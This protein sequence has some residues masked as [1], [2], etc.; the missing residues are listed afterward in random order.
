VK[1]GDS[2]AK[3]ALALL[4]A[5]GASVLCECVN[6][7]G[8]RVAE[9]RA[10]LVDV[11]WRVLDDVVEQAGD[12][13]LLVGAGVAQESATACAWGRPFARADRNAVVGIEK[14]IDR[15]ATN[16]WE[17]FPNATQGE[18]AA[19]PPFDVSGHRLQPDRLTEAK[20]RLEEE[21]Q[22]ECRANEATR[23]TAATGG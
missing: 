15:S 10:H 2:R 14:E 6:H 21:H 8:E 13:G 3:H 7:R 11:S 16:S 18:G 17:S 23:I 4:V 22:V 1:R 9:H 20:R 5:F 12:L 19:G